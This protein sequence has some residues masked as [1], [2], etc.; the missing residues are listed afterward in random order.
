MALEIERLIITHGR[1]ILHSPGMQY[2]KTQKQHGSISCF[3]HSVAV[4]YVSV[5]LAMS[6]NIKADMRSLI[7]G[8]LLH[9]YFLYDWRDNVESS[10]PHGFIHARIALNNANRDFLLGDIEKDIILR[11]MF[12]L[13]ITPPRYLESVIVCMADKLCAGVEFAACILPF[14]TAGIIIGAGRD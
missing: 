1:D 11:H 10:R 12:P 5:W 14:S 4:A 7:R 9:D 6:A 13:N 2:E 3:E 8:A